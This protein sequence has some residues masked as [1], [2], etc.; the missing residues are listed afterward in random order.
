MTPK[1]CKQAA[2]SGGASL[3]PPGCDYQGR[4]ETQDPP[5][6][7][8]ESTLIAGVYLASGT[9]VCSLIYIVL[10]LSGVL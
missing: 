10:A 5:M 9:A 3:H 6:L 8:C 4:Y 2:F 1:Q 7:P